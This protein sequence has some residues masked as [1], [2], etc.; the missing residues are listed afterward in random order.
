MY[1]TDIYATTPPGIGLTGGSQPHEN[2]PPFLVLSLCIALQGVFPSQNCMRIP[3]Y[4]EIM[5][6]GGN[7]PPVG[8]DST[9]GPPFRSP[10]T[11]RCSS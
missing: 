5:M 4:G 9:S 1:S 10:R 6:F 3:W 11:T 7:F 8:W 2:L